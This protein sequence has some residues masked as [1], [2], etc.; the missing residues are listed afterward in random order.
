M[1]NYKA[2]F[3]TAMDHYARAKRSYNNNDFCDAFEKAI[4]CVRILNV[5]R[6]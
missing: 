6:I 5:S 1:S 2:W 4:C 3:E